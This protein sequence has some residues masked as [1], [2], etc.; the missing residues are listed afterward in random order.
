MLNIDYQRSLA[1]FT[2]SILISNRF[3]LAFV[4]RV[5]AFIFSN[6]DGDLIFANVAVWF[7]CR[8]WFALSDDVLLGE[9]LGAF[10]SVRLGAFA[11]EA[12]GAF[13]G[14]ERAFGTFRRWHN[15]WLAFGQ[16]TTARVIGISAAVFVAALEVE[17]ERTA[18]LI[19]VSLA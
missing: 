17:R 9:E 5:A 15:K 13:L 16:L 3:G 18:R 12:F 19:A 10:I 8:L 11:F 2:F 14:L 1:V 4:N 7:W 6:Y